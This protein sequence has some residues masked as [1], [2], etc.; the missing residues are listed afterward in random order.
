MRKIYLFDLANTLLYKPSFYTNFLEVLHE[1]GVNIPVSEFTCRHRWLSELI[2]FPDKTSKSFYEEFNGKLLLSMGIEPRQM[3]LDEIFAACTYLPWQPFEDTKA[4]AHIHDSKAILSNWD[5]SV[6]EKVESFFP[7]QF[8][9][10]F[11]SALSGLRKPNAAFFQKAIN[12]LNVDPSQ[13]TYVGDSLKLDIF[14]ALHLGIN[15]ILIDRNHDYP[16][17]QGKKIH[18][19]E[20]LIHVSD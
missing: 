20:E 7:G 18:S 19:L 4:I 11:G 17:Y 5:E 3:L 9:A 6:K 10:V 15:A 13:I 14:P 12:E 16:F 8:E 2:L 1:H